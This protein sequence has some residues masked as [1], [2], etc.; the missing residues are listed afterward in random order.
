MASAS[1]CA[2][3]PSEHVA[4]H[5]ARLLRLSGIRTDQAAVR[6][7]STV[8]QL[9]VSRRSS[10]PSTGRQ[11]TVSWP[12]LGVSETCALNVI[13]CG[14]AGSCHLAATPRRQLS[15]ASLMTGVNEVRWN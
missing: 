5:P 7:G 8:D 15:K 1:R 3:R 11:L 2:S 9:T 6:H 10:A 14:E 13:G 12:Q 4:G